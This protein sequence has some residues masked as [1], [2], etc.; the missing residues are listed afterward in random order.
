MVDADGCPQKNTGELMNTL[1]E[2]YTPYSLNKLPY[3]PV[4]IPL[5]ILFL[6]KLVNSSTG[7]FLCLPS[8]V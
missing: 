4:P 8:T 3:L 6:V 1:L 2:R 5:D 7:S